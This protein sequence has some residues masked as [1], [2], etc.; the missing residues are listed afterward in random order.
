MCVSVCLSVCRRLRPER[1]LDALELDLEVAL[2]HSR[3]C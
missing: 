3:V 1:T 2:H